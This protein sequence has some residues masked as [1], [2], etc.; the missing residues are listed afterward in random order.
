[1]IDIKPLEVTEFSKGVTDYYID[2]NQSEAQELDNF[3]LKPNAKP[4][5][6][7][8]SVP[9]VTAQI[10]LGQFRIS[11]LTYLRD[12]VAQTDNLLTFSQK[13]IYTNDGS[14]WTELLSPTVLPPFSEGDANSLPSSGEWRGH[15]LL[16]NSDFSE[17]QKAFYDD[18]STL[19]VQSAGLP[20]FPLT[21]LSITDPPGA[22]STYSYILIFKYSYK[23]GDSTNLDRGPLTFYPTIVSGGT[24]A[25]G[26]GAVITLPT[27]IPSPGNYDV[28][29]FDVEIYRTQTG[30]ADYFLVDTVSFGTANYTD[31]VIDALLSVPLY[32]ASISYKAPPK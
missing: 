19:R 4:I 7:W 8:G 13:R 31:E 3:F 20:T 16:A 24:I 11:K 6:R 17:V 32:S 1:M 29:N 22:G 25:P 23:V 14:A 9:H 28:S 10:P 12:T 18:S 15:L 30:D 26:N 21:G 27:T 2:G 5:T